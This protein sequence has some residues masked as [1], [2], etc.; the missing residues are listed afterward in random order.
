[1]SSHPLTP[2]LLSALQ[3]INNLLA[4]TFFASGLDKQLTFCENFHK[5]TDEPATLGGNG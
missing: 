5:G 3:R 1:M 4:D 2:R